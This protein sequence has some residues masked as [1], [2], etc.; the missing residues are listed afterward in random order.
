MAVTVSTE[1]ASAGQLV[2]H[3]CGFCSITLIIVPNVALPL[4]GSIVDLAAA[5][6]A[7]AASRQASVG[8][9]FPS[10]SMRPGPSEMIRSS[11]TC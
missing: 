1:S 4:L 6:T 8:F 7:F 10:E 11:R 9:R 2:V 3:F 5:S